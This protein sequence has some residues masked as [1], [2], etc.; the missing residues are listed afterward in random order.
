MQMPLGN[1]AGLSGRSAGSRPAT[2][3]STPV[4]TGATNDRPASAGGRG[5]DG[6]AALGL[7]RSEAFSSWLLGLLEEAVSIDLV[8]SRSFDSW[9]RWT[10]WR[11]LHGS[12]KL[13]PGE[14]E[15]PNSRCTGL[16]QPDRRLA[17]ICRSDRGVTALS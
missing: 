2:G 7:D 3:R 8:G 12:V 10:T 13:R 17:E 6:T 4:G 14:P 11:E 9:Q 1:C 16:W 15:T 5:A